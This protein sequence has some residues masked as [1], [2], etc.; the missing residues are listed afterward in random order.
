LVLARPED[1]PGS[2]VRKGAMLG[3][4]LTPGSVNVRTLLTGED[5]PLVRERARSAEV[6]LAERPDARLPARIVADMP[7]AIQVL[8][9]AA[10]SDR[11]G[12]AHR[13]DPA[14]SAGLRALEPVFQF[15]VALLD[16]KL[17][18]VGGRAWVRF[19]LGNAPLALQWYRRASQLLLAHFNPT[20]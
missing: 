13:T 5:A 11:A 6:R 1:L 16:Q 17:E 12:G 8:P 15:D 20:Q 10:F 7:G 3:Y 19:D 2:F 14:D 9:N 18:R 4:V